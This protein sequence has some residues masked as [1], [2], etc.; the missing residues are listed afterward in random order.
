MSNDLLSVSTMCEKLNGIHADLD[1]PLVWSVKEEAGVL[2]LWQYDKKR[3]LTQSVLSG[4]TAD[5][6]YLFLQGY[7][8][9]M[10]NLSMSV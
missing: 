3:E 4:R 9:A 1:K 5:E 6:S 2:S 7:Y 8:L 10:R